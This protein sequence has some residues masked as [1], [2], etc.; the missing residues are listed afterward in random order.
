VPVEQATPL[1]VDPRIELTATAT[2][3]KVGDLVTI[4]GVAVD[5][6]L[7]YYY[8]V[9]RDDGVQDMPPLVMVT[10]ENILTVQ[11][12]TSQVVEFVSAEGNNNQVTFELKAK[13]PGVTTVSIEA[14]GEIHSSAGTN[15]NGGGSGSVV[16]TVIP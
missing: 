15:W 12:G 6:G 14:T 4:Q 16:I 2:T 3:L 10:Y 8:L 13:A 9:V 5:I 11:N 7:P 1:P